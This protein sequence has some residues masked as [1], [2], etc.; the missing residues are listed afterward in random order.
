VD[1][2]LPPAACDLLE[3][4]R[5][6]APQLA[7]ARWLV[8][9][10]SL[11]MKAL[12]FVPG[13]DATGSCE[14]RYR[15]IFRPTPPCLAPHSPLL[16]REMVEY[17]GEVMD[18]NPIVFPVRFATRNAAVQT[19]T[20]EV[21][22]TGVFV[23][24][25]EPPSMG[26]V[27]GM[28]LYLPGSAEAME[29]EGVVR[30]VA[31]AGAESGFWAEFNGMAPHQRAQVAELIARR[32]RASVAKPIG[33]VAVQPFD[34]PRRAFPRHAVRFAVRFA[35]VQDFVLEYAANISA[36]G[37][38]V[39]TENPLPLKTVVRVEM[40]LPGSNELVP[41]R[42]MVVHRVTAEEAKARGTLAG[43][44]V[45]FLDADDTFRDHISAAI[46]HILKS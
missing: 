22:R 32:D 42:G 21:S 44:G 27:I 31:P 43:M 24:C 33:A 30:E 34:D 2:R 18:R 36:G 28:K 14:F 39:Q 12:L 16:V 6:E 9:D 8:L 10:L 5:D 17:T 37:V 29:V 46:D 19:T 1:R 41:A 38:F 3:W 26:T 13:K 11:G 25:L 40:E 15:W 20:R 23:R 35:T 7:A 4:V 45:Q